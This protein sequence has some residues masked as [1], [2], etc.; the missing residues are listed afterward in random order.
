MLEFLRLSISEISILP[1][2]ISVLLSPA[3]FIA[4][5]RVAMAAPLRSATVVQNAERE[6]ERRESHSRQQEILLPLDAI[7]AD[8]VRTV[9]I[10]NS[11]VAREADEE[12]AQAEK[13]QGQEEEDGAAAE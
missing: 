7:K 6:R 5:S 2:L 9:R 8:L 12:E 4:H 1:P 11:W 10:R 13:Y 3:L